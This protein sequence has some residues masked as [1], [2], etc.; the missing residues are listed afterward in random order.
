MK[1]Y[2]VRFNGDADLIDC[3]IDGSKDVDG[4]VFSYPYCYMQPGD[5]IIYYTEAIPKGGNFITTR[6][7]RVIIT[8]IK[9]YNT[10][11]EFVF[12]ETPERIMPTIIR[13]RK[14]DNRKSL[15]NILDNWD[16]D[17]TLMLD[18]TVERVLDQ[19]NRNSLP[20]YREYLK[21]TYGISFMGIGIRY[22]Q[23]ISNLPQLFNMFKCIIENENITHASEITRQAR[24]QERFFKSYR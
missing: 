18:N 12:Y 19:F 1:V 7:V 24:Y 21:R 10:L 5:E 22:I 14:L 8:Y 16:M 20:E 23:N 4:M 15:D 13:D 9:Y 3:I 6:S 17:H 11:E 2:N